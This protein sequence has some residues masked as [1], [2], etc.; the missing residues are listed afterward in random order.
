MLKNLNWTEVELKAF[1]FAKE[2][3][4]GQK[5][6]SGGDFIEHPILVATFLKEAGLDE[7]VVASG[8]L[9]DTVEDT[10]VILSDIYDIFGNVVGDLVKSNNEDKSKS[11]IERKVHTHS[12]IPFLSYEERCLLIADKYAN[13]IS[14]SQELKTNPHGV[15]DLFNAGYE[16]QKWY[17]KNIS[18]AVFVNVDYFLEDF[19]DYFRDYQKIVE[20]V[21]I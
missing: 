19:P 12:Q 11:W 5:R 6:K 13:V 15:W 18:Y 10:E 16:S 17:Y 7:S 1:D 3:H 9:H 21:F 4:K 2:A 20:K 14:I 8:F